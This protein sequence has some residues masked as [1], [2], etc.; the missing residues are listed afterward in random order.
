M[1]KLDADQVIKKS[2]DDAQ[3][4]LKITGT[5]AVSNSVGQD[6]IH[7][8][9]VDSADIEA[10]SGNYFEVVASTSATVSEIKVYDTTGA[11]LE[12]ATGAAASEVTKIVVGPGSD[13]TFSVNIPAG[14]RVSIRSREVSAPGAGS[15]FIVNLIG[16]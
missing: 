16:G 12:L 6:V 4:A 7:S 14:T 13:Q 11:T 3:E 8:V 9:E 1:A 5:V 2:Y 10:V 15:N